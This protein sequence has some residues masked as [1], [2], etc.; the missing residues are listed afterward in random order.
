M[1]RTLCAVC[2]YFM[3]YVHVP[4]LCGPSTSIAWYKY[5]YCVLCVPT[6]FGISTYIFWYTYPHSLVNVFTF[7][8]HGTYIVC[9][10]VFQDFVLDLVVMICVPVSLALRNPSM[11][12]FAKNW[13]ESRQPFNW[14]V[15]LKEKMSNR[16]ESYTLRNVIVPKD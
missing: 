1:C 8:V 13:I 15:N 14:A 11:K 6:L 9:Y 16:Y 12:S 2:T 5:L 7:L 3:C 4:T 10:I